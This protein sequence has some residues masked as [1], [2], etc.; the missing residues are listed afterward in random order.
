ML[1]V[2]ALGY[3]A[4]QRWPIIGRIIEEYYGSFLL[5]IAV[6]ALLA[7]LLGAIGIEIK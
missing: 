3:D 1:G 2:F 5:V 6:C 7:I 4:G